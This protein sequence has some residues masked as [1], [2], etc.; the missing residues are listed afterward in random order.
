MCAVRKYPGRVRILRSGADLW[1][2]FESALRCAKGVATRPAYTFL[3]P[4]ERSEFA[5]EMRPPTDA[6]TRNPSVDAVALDN[7]R[8]WTRNSL[9][10]LSEPTGG[11]LLVDGPELVEGLERISSAMRH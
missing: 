9:R 5:I 7:Y 10:A 3:R 8:A 11:F 4:K 1:S 2:G 6:L